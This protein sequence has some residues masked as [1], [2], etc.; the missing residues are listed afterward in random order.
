M[1]IGKKILTSLLGLALTGVLAVAVVSFAG[2]Y[3]IKDTL[4]SENKVTIDS[5]YLQSTK[6]IEMQSESVGVSMAESYANEI[7]GYFERIISEITAM[8]GSIESIGNHGGTQEKQELDRYEEYIISHIVE[9]PPEEEKEIIKQFGFVTAL[10]D[11]LLAAE[12]NLSLAYLV[13][14]NG[15]VISSTDTFYKEV[16][17]TD[18]R[19]RTWYR[20]AVQSKDIVWSELYISETNGESYITCAVP[21]YKGGEELLGVVAFDLKTTD[22]SQ[23]LLTSKKNFIDNSFLFDEEG[24]VL[25]ST[26]GNEQVSEAAFYQD[27]MKEWDHQKRGF[28]S[29]EGIMIGYARIEETNWMLA[30]MLD[31]EYM[32]DPFNIIGESVKMAGENMN[33]FIS[34]RISGNIT[35]FLIVACSVMILVVIMAN[36]IGKS[37]TK[38]IY[39]LSDGVR[40]IS[41]GNLE[42]KL[43]VKS[44]DEIEELSEAVNHMTGELKEY[45]EN[46]Q[47]VTIEKERIGAELNVATTIQASMLP[48][49]FPAFP[50]REEINIYASMLPAKEVG[51]DFYDFFLIGDN[52]LGIVMADV[53][54]KGVP[55]ALFM[56]IAK[57][58][59][60]NNAQYGKQPK[61]I[62]QTVNNQLCENNDAGMF[63]TAFMGILEI[64]TGKFSYVNAGH[65]QPLIQK[66]GKYKWLD[67]IPGFVLAGLEDIV[68][69]QE[70]ISLEKGDILYLYTDGVTEA[71][72]REK[73]LFGDDKLFDC[74]NQYGKI[75]PKELLLALKSEIDIFADGE[76][77][78]DDI[79]ML[80]IKIE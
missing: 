36:I 26:L 52:Q 2:L 57:T 55:A 22:I 32:M 38:P 4:K 59:I 63:V 71:M 77:Q 54:G 8:K 16:E 62:F 24:T 28:Y 35:L 69:Q 67:T 46:L 56:V 39:T 19:R 9:M 34:Q 5:L 13:L 11:N 45:I 72:N 31:Y 21:V 53:S 42:Y 7:N 61:E 23:K 25:L 50:E 43:S 65:N 6:T 74:I 27:F 70:E 47:E 73:E 66:K 60:K 78:A 1:S 20:D 10:F 18:M 75:G 17:K 49:I 76:E 80:A 44:G 51:G 12:Q 37:I 79:T 29:K 3:Q 15:M 48:C 64:S 14:E 40:I 68:Y 41:R 30:T 33:G 58:L